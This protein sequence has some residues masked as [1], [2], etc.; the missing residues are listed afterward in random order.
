MKRNLK[1][2]EKKEKIKNNFFFKL[3]FDEKKNKDKNGKENRKK[4]ENE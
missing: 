4:N 3:N 1:L 2:K